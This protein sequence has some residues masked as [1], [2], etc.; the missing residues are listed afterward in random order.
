MSD[1]I[2]AAQRAA[3]GPWRVVSGTA[4][5]VR[6]S[7]SSEPLAVVQF[8]EEPDPE[9]GHVGWCW[10][11]MGAMG[12]AP[13]YEEACERALAEVERRREVKL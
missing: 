11:A 8:T 3:S 13:T 1:H 10:W 5:A 7:E 12:D 6:S 9:T 2:L 4:V